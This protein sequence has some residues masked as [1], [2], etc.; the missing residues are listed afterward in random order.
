VIVAAH[1]IVAV[2]RNV[3]VAVHANGNGPPVDARRVGAP[4]VF[5]LCEA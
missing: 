2:A 1:V 5:V 4:R 3:I